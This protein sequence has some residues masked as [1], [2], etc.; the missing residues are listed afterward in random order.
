MTPADAR[1][2]ALFAHHA[3]PA[4]DPAF[5]AAVVERLVRRRCLQDLALLG[6]LSTVGGVA[7]WGLWPVLQPALIAVSD[8][9]APS[10]WALAV[11]FCAVAALGGLGE[12]A[13]AVES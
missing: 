4:R 11:A 2:K 6:G 12:R 1:L 5:S 9:L 7:L 3:P 8:R 13:P 10:A